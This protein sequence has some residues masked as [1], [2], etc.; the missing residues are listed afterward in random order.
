MGATSPEAEMLRGS[1]IWVGGIWGA[2]TGGTMARVA[3]AAVGM[4]GRVKVE[5]RRRPVLGSSRMIVFTLV[6]GERSPAQAARVRQAR[7]VRRVKM[8]LINRL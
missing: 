4:A 8:I 6:F 1:I 2:T 7:M 3:R 5:R